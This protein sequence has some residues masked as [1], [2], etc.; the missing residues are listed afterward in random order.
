[1]LR[2]PPLGDRNKDTDS[3][4]KGSSITCLLATPCIID[5][6]QEKGLALGRVS[7]LPPRRALIKV[8]LI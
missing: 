7:T 2:N 3:I 8:S 5:G 6:L 1:M 4:A